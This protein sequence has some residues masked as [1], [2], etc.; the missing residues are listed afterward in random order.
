[1]PTREQA[2][3]VMRYGFGTELQKPEAWRPIEQGYIIDEDRFVDWTIRVNRK[4]VVVHR[5]DPVGFKEGG[6]W[7]RWRWYQQDAGQWREALRGGNGRDAG[8][9]RDLLLI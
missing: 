7:R 4:R 9:M 3:V 2:K 6:G 8:S 5:S 1:L